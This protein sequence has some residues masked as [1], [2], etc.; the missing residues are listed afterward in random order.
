[1]KNLAAGIVTASVIL[2]SGCATIINDETQSIN[3][4]TS[5]NTEIEAQVGG[6]Q[7][8]TPASVSV[9]R[10]KDDLVVQT[11]NEKC[12][13]STSVE[14][15]VDD[16]F[17]INILSGGVFGSTTDYSSEEMWEYDSDVVVNCN[18]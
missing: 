12:S 9:K 10:A 4:R 5:N 16:V 1:M 7:V 17:F 14:S 18:D 3:V 13:P 11:S 8:T 15:S 2:T 6:Q